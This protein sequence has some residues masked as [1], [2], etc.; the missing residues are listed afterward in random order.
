MQVRVFGIL[1]KDQ[2]GEDLAVPRHPLANK[3]MRKRTEGGVVFYV[4]GIREMM[5]GCVVPRLADERTVNEAERLIP[6]VVDYT[7]CQ[8]LGKGRTVPTAFLVNF[9]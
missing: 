7:F 3:N 9:A 4:C 8:F 1:A 5:P 2:P 6:K